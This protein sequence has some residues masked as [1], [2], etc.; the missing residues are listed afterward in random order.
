[1]SPI[2]TVSL[3]LFRFDTF[4]SRF[5]VLGQM[6]AARLSLPRVPGIGFWRLCGSGTGQGFTPRP[7]FGVWAILATWTD[8]R[9]AEDQTRNA[10]VFR[11][12]RHRSGEAWTVFL[13]PTAARGAWSG[14]QPFE[15]AGQDVVGPVAALTR[16]TVRLSKARQFWRHEPEISKRVGADPN[17]I[18]K[19]GIGEVPLIH[20]VTFSIWPDARSMARF[21][22]SEG[23]HADAIRAVKRE[24]YFKEELY[25]RFQVL[26]DRGTWHGESPIANIDRPKVAA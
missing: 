11:Q 17:V 10:P 14:R 2:Q 16:A 22:R 15:G 19:I 1:M 5:W 13:E 25:A 9:T 8:R 7:N 24:G 6:G 20:Q 18:F 21:A 4:A 3:S 23:S 12:F 26:G